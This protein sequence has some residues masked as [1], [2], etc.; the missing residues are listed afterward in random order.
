[1]IEGSPRMLRINTQGGEG[2]EGGG[3]NPAINRHFEL[4]INTLQNAPSD[5]E[6]LEQL[7]K[8]KQRRKDEAMH[9]EDMQRLVTEEIEMLKVVSCIW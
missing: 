9:I 2:K 3:V 8:I 6:K 1:M 4:E 7:L 5:P